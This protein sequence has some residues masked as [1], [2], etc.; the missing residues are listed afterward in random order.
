[1]IPRRSA[2][3]KYEANKKEN[4]GEIEAVN[5]FMQAYGL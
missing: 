3:K 2:E 5:K 1:M 4:G